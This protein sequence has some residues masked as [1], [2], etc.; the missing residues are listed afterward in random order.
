MELMRYV[1][2][3]RR[4]AWLLALSSLVAALASYAITY[5]LPH[6]YQSDATLLIHPAEGTSVFGSILSTDQIQ[7]NYALLMLQRPMLDRV[8]ADLGLSEGGDALQSHVKVTPIPNTTILTIQVQESSGALAAAIAN[9]LADDFIASQNASHKAQVDS[10]VGDLQRQISDSQGQVAA[11][12]AELDRLNALAAKGPISAELSSQLSATGARLANDN[13]QV[14]NLGGKLSEAKA[15]AARNFDTL[16]I[17]S[18]AIVPNRPVGPNL[19]L[20]VAAAFAAGLLFALGVALLLEHLDQSIKGDEDMGQRTGLAVI[21]HLGFV[22]GREGRLGELVALNG[23][24]PVAEAYKAL[25]TN[26]LFATVDRDAR[27]IVVTS[28]LPFEGKSRTAA[29]LAIVLAQAGHRTLIVDADFRRPTQHKLFGRARNVGLSN[30]ILDEKP[31]EELIQPV[32][33]AHFLYFLA[34]GTTPSNPS[35]LLG[36]N[37]MR[38]VLDDLRRQFRYIVLDTPPTNAVT[39]SAVLAAFADATVIVAEHGRTTYPALNHARQSLER[40]GANIVGVVVNKVKE[41]PGAYY[42]RYGY[43]AA[44]GDQRR[45]SPAP[46]AP[47]PP[48]PAGTAPE[49]RQ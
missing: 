26:L 40:V 43:Y 48:L 2:L 22:P 10:L 1:R 28:A 45:E 21:A 36:S 49:E 44:L 33:Q 27:S 37:R 14:A 34:A 24:S 3:L 41:T 31:A 32:D 9:K 4:W 46:R 42:Y 15:S 8:A 13:N 29:N 38:A 19:P 39:D 5:R 18:P 7:A 16:E 20:N 12:K 17:V 47:G 25:R 35:E 11:D 23:N 6:V 30:L